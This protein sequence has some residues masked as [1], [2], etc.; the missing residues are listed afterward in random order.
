MA[1]SGPR[2][3]GIA[4]PFWFVPES[5]DAFGALEMKESDIVLSTYPKCGTTWTQKILSCL[6]RMDA[7]GVMSAA[8]EVGSTGQVYPDG[9][10]LER[11]PEPHPI[12][13]SASIAELFAQRDPRLFSSH[14][15]ASRLPCL[16]HG[17][18]RLIYVL[19]NP[20]DTATSLHFF[21]G[22]AKDDWLGNEHGPGSLN[23]FLADPAPNAFGAY[24]DHILEMEELV[25]KLGP[26]RALVLYYE[27]MKGDHRGQVARIAKFLGMPVTDKL[28]DAVVA[29]TAFKAMAAERQG[30]KLAALTRKGVIGDWEGHLDDATWSRVDT[31]FDERCGQSKLYQPMK[32]W[33]VAQNPKL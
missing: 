21:M 32:Q 10:P 11:P 19:R 27:E 22:A 29:A 18:G 26:D 25:E 15:P 12:F 2:Y 30:T 8:P 6:R 3:H 16:T 23:R 17:K 20:K 33:M 14:L 24:W 1:G 7:D 31:L 9:I 4:T 13:G 5:A 28:L